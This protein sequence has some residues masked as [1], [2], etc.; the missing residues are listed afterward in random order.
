MSQERGHTERLEKQAALRKATD[1]GHQPTR[2]IRH[3]FQEYVGVQT[4]LALHGDPGSAPRD[5][6]LRLLIN[7]E[8][9]FF[10][11][12]IDGQSF[13]FVFEV[14]VGRT[15]NL[16]HVVFARACCDLS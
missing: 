14:T 8:E 12:N 5:P 11:Q 15:S 9:Q 3:L 13:L 1:A 10:R 4:R 16:R 2:S 7:E 6:Q